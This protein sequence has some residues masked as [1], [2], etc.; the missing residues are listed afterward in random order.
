M[1]WRLP[2]FDAR[3]PIIARVVS[4]VCVIMLGYST[5]LA[6]TLKCGSI[7][8]GRNG[9]CDEENR[10]SP[11]KIYD[12]RERKCEHVH[13]NLRSAHFILEAGFLR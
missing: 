10:Y 5:L 8:W 11:S 12:A 13:H 3:R 1:C 7:Y 9:D 6:S 4:E 2:S